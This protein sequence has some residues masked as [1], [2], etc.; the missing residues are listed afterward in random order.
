MQTEAPS[1]RRKG[2]S[3]PLMESSE[4]AAENLAHY[5]QQLAAGV[6]E[7]IGV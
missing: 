2:C 6:P 4:A 7:R 5:V 3:E 1:R